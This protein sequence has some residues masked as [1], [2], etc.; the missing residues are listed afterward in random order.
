MKHL[1]PTII[2][3]LLG[4]QP[5][6]SLPIAPADPNPPKPVKTSVPKGPTLKA[7]DAIVTATNQFGFKLLQKLPTDANVMVSPLSISLA[8]RMAMNG[9]A[10]DT[11]RQMSE[12]LGLG[13]VDQSAINANSESIQ[14]TLG[15]DPAAEISVANSIWTRKGF[16]FQQAYLDSISKSYSAKVS[17]IDFKDSGAPKTI[18]GWVSDATKG[19]I[20]TIVPDPLPGDAVMYLV[21]AVYFKGKWAVPFESNATQ[22]ESFTLADGSTLKTPMMHRDRAEGITIEGGRTGAIMPYRDGAFEMVAILPADHESP[23]S[24]LPLLAAKDILATSEPMGAVNL[25]FPKFR[26]TFDASL[27]AP[28]KGLGMQMPFSDAA[29]FSKMRSQKDIAISEVRHKTFIDVTEEGTEAAAVTSIEMKATAVMMK[30]KEL[31][32]NRPFLYLIRHHD[33]GQILFVGILQNPKA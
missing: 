21:N 8:L 13:S 5:P 28:L 23:S 31:N 7:K 29:D 14:S 3:A 19:K 32:F 17:N 2:L 25:S 12:G 9:A 11:F 22:P 10:G 16:P 27:V 4:C 1:M 18:N 33:S 6:A 26:V 24:L 15:S 20:D 30:P